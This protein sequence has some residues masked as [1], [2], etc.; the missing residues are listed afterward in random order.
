MNYYNE[1]DPSAIAWLKELIKAGAIPDGHIDTRSICEVQPEELHGFDQCH[2]FAGIGGWSEAL[3]LANYAHVKG[4]WTGSCPCQ[5]FSAAGKRKGTADARHLWPE[6]FRLVKAC[7]PRYVIGEQ[8][9]AAIRAGWLDGVFGDLE[10]EGY[11]CGAAVLGAHS[12]GAPHIRQRLY[13]GAAGLADAE[14]ERLVGRNVGIETDPE[15]AALGRGPKPDERRGWDDATN[16]GGAML[17]LADADMSRCDE[18]TPVREQSVHC[19]DSRAI[20]SGLE[21]S[22][23]ER[24]HE[25]REPKATEVQ[26]ERP[27]GGGEPAV[28]GQGGVVSGRPEG[29][30]AIATG[31]L[32]HAAREQ[33]GIPGQSREQR[34][35][36]GLGD[37]DDPRPQGYGPVVGER[38]G[39]LSPWAASTTIYC[40]DGKTRRI[41][42]EPEFQHVVD[43]LSD[44]LEYLRPESLAQEEINLTMFPLAANVSGRVGLLRGYG[45]AI[46]PAVAAEFIVAF[47]ESANENMHEV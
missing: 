13:W 21:H 8:V 43:G 26:R 4:L 22:A 15:R 38:A 14:N 18:R 10:G 9:E 28:E 23:N 36:G 11:A 39:E 12:V 24:R 2:F 33:V 40:A 5:P 47:M 7:K 32:E 45:N 3:R 25:R 16:G 41:S 29:L 6:M 44:Y 37:P 46:V 27:I 30:G 42:V 17:R 34:D 35:T 31:G 19:E 1:F 20:P